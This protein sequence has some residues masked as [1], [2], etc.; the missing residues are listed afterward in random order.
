[1]DDRA[2]RILK[3]VAV[4]L[5]VALVGFAVHHEF[6]AGVA[7]GDQDYFAGNRALADADYARAEGAYRDALGENPGHVFALLGLAQS[8]HKQGQRE[9]A[10]ATYDEAVAHAPDLAGAY[11]NRGLLLD[12]MGRRE[13]ALADY[14]RALELDPEIADGPNWLTRFL[15]TQAEAP[16]SVADRARHLRAELSKPAAERALRVPDLDEQQR[17]YQE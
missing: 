11:A 13:E 10:L 16:P 1:M 7:P 8:L 14:M 4:V 9:R 3:L 17:R 2:R 5:A 15:R 6:V 12:T